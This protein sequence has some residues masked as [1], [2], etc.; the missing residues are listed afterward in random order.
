MLVILWPLPEAQAGTV[1]TIVLP[2]KTFTVYRVEI[3]SP[4]GDPITAGSAANHFTLSG[5]NGVA[6]IPVQ[7]VVAPSRVTPNV[8]DLIKWSFVA[9]PAG[10]AVSWDHPWPGDPSSGQGA[11]AIATLT[12]YPAN[13]SDFGVKTLK[14]VLIRKSDGKIF[15]QRETNIALFFERDAVA[16]GRTDPNWFFYWNQTGAGDSNALFSSTLS[17]PGLVPAGNQ[18][19]T[20]AGPRRRIFIGFG[21]NGTYTRRDGSNEEVS[22]IAMFANV[23]LHERRHVDQIFDNN[24]LAF[25]SG[26]TGVLREAAAAGWSFGVAFST[27]S[28]WNHFTDT[29]GNG[30][31]DVPP[32]TDLDVDRDHLGDTIQPTAADLALCATPSSHI[33]CQAQLAETSPKAAFT[34]VDWA[35]PGK[36]HY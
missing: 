14:M 7:A 32:D 8:S 1:R 3:Q 34:I 25:Y 24:A 20:Y 36:Q 26:R 9:L 30:F 15:N 10:V 5:P 28:L 29:N 17:N 22:G 4:T 27:T 6:T 11:S 12:G 35:D 16:T 33:E 2:K 18:W 21:A 31:Y 13:N 23:I 19:L